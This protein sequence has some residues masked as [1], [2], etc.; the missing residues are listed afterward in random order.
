M[1][2]TS[3]AE[4][5]RDCF[6]GIYEGRSN[7]VVVVEAGLVA[8]APVALATHVVALLVDLGGAPEPARGI[9]VRGAAQVA[10]PLERERQH[11][12]VPC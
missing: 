8:V 9:R 5:C 12:F 2:I 6:I 1:K 11:T 10:H 3:G 4:K 7:D